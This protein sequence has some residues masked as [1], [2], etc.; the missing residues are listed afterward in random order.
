[1][2]RYEYVISILGTRNRHNCGLKG[3]GL[4]ETYLGDEEFKYKPL[5]PKV[6]FLARNNKGIIYEEEKPKGRAAHI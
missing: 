3:G 1:M 5:A 4:G 2:E 6:L